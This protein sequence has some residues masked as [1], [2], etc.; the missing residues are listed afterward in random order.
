MPV[1]G[2][3]AHSD[4]AGII[5]FA[6][7][8][9]VIALVAMLVGAVFIISAR[10]TY[11]VDV[12]PGEE[13]LLFRYDVPG[14]DPLPHHLRVIVLSPG[15]FTVGP[16]AEGVGDEVVLRIEETTNGEVV[17]DEANG[18]LRLGQ[19]IWETDAAPGEQWVVHITNHGNTTARV[20]GTASSTSFYVAGG[21]LVAVGV[22]GFVSYRLGIRRSE[23]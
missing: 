13:A 11:V 22:L 16:E 12:E 3:V 9:V 2:A 14:W 8:F 7:I 1:G 20:S 23:E 21:V 6:Q 18:T 15:N 19:A 17:Q 10:E 5:R 4:D